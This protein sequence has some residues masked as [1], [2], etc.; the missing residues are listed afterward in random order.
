M[1]PSEILH[2]KIVSVI[3]EQKVTRYKIS[4]DTG[5]SPTSLTNFYEG[6][7]DLTLPNFNTLC[8]YFG[9]EL[10]PKGKVK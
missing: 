3:E 1:S 6:T 7:S 10:H 8:A 4:K 5:I 9:F 2:A